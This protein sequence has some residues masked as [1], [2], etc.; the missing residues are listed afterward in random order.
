MKPR[1]KQI[2]TDDW[3]VDLRLPGERNKR[4][5]RSFPTKAAAE[6]F[7]DDI[8]AGETPE[9]P[10]NLDDQLD[11]YLDWS[12]RV[13]GKSPRTMRV[14]RTR[15]GVFRKWAK[16][17]GITSP[18]QI[19]YKAILAFQEYYFMNAPFDQKRVRQRYRP[20]Q[21]RRT[22]EKYRQIICAF[23][24][25]CRKRGAAT[26]P[27][28]AADHDFK[29]KLPPTMPRIFT[30]DELSKVFAY[31]DERDQDQKTPWM[32]VMLRTLAYTGMRLGELQNLKWSDI[33]LERRL[34][35]ITKSKSMKVRS[36]PING[37]LLPWLTALPRSGELLFSNGNGGYLYTQSWIHKQFVDACDAVVIDRGRLHDLRHTFAATLAQ[38]N[39]PLPTIQ[40]LLGHETPE[41][42]MRVYIHYYPKHL[43]EATEKLDY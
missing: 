31:F 27:N 33:D 2:A 16:G 40:A 1:P 5:R 8:L 20:A 42:T 12:E 37:K 30:P 14:D 43:E 18:Q 15:L 4:F 17:Q 39:V 21:P 35:R 13:K 28:P 11:S 23:L 29:I 7:I 26:G 22:W 3:R 6:Q 41:M 19:D 38:N 34:I 24:N 32:S 10:R 25:W 36:I 9:T